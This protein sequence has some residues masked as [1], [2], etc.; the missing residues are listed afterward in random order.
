MDRE[1]IVNIPLSTRRQSDFWAWHYDKID[2]FTVRSTYRMLVFRKYNMTACFDS[3]AG[4]SN[5]KADEKEWIA[6]WHVQVPAKIRVFLWR[7][8][9]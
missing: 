4:R 8:A 1:V 6:L 2:I 9:R 5:T 3:V 7:L